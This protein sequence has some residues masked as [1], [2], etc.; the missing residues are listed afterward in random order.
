MKIQIN[1][2]ACGNPL[3]C[4][5]CLDRCPEKVFGTYPQ[6]RRKPGVPASDWT[7]FAIFASECTGCM[8]CVAFCP[9]HAISVR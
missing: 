6:G 5:L 9:Q 1:A 2:Q 8:E 7:I 3:D 4:R